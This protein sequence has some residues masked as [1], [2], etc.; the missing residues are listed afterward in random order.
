[1]AQGP[2]HL[3][4]HRQL[5]NDQHQLFVRLIQDGKQTDENDLVDQQKSDS[6]HLFQVSKQ[7]LH[8]DKYPPLHKSYSIKDSNIGTV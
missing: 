6:E 2:L 8:L 5:Y 1:M 3:E 7:L 4:M